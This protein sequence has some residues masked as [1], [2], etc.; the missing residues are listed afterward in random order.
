MEY[1]QKCSIPLLLAVLSFIII[2]SACSPEPKP[3]IFHVG[4]SQCCDDA[5]RD[6]MNRE[7]LRELAFHPEL[8]F[9]IR[10]AGNNSQ[11]QIEQI[12]ELIDSGID[13]LIV[14]PNESEPLTQLVTKV[15]KSGIPVILI[16][17]KIDSEQYSAY[18]GA[19]N[20]EIGETAAKYIANQF[21]GK[22]NIIE[23]Q[24]G[25]TM[26]PA[27][28]RNQGFRDALTKFPQLQIVVPLEMSK[29]MEALKVD[30][31]TTIGQHPEI[32]IVFAHN[33][34]LAENAYTWAKEIGRADDLF[35]IGIDGIPG[36]SKGI[37]AVEDG[38]LNATL[39]YPTGGS[40]AIR[41]ALSMLNNLPFDKQNTLQT[42]VINEDNARI[43]HLQM[44]KVENLQHSIDEQTKG[45]ADLKTV[46]QNQQV[47]IAVLI[48]SLLLAI[49]LGAVLYQSLRSKE[50]INK[51][52]EAK[53]QEALEHEQ[54]IMQMSDQLRLASQAKVEFFT[55][56]S[57]EFRTPLTLI[58]G[59][60]EGLLTT[61][62]I[63][64]KEAKQDLGMVRKN[65]LRLLRLVNQLM[66]F[67]KIES[68]KMAVRAS[69]N[70]LIIFAKDIV[71]AYQKMADKRNIDL[72]FLAH[73]KSILVWFDVNM[74]DKV[75]FNLLSNAFKFTSNGGKIIVSVVKD[76]INNKAIL[77]V[78]DTGRGMT[79]EHTDRAFEQFYQGQN[80]K[81]IGTGLGLSLS[82]ELANLHNGDIKLW[83]ELGKGTRFEVSL[84]LGSLHF[85]EEQLITSKTESIS[86]TE[87][88]LIF[89]EDNQPLASQ[90][91]SEKTTKQSLLLI[92]DNAEM[93]V[94]FKNHFGKIYDIREAADGNT[95]LDLAFEEVPD[96]VVA[97]ITMPGKDGLELAKNLKSDLRTSHI[98]IVLLTARNSMEQKIEGIQTGADAYVT[99][100]FNLVFL[101]EIIKNLLQ[102]RE[103]LR[104]R[105]GGA[106]QLG[107]LPSDLGDLDQQFL[108][109][110][111]TF[112]E[113]NYADLNLTVENLSIEFGL[114]RVQLFRKT[115][116]LLGDSPNNFIQHVR[117]KKASQFLLDS[118]WTVAEIAYKTGYSTPGYFSTAFKGKYGLTPTEWREGKGER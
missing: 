93:R 76:A 87:E 57:H 11:S 117:L 94:F 78:E 109:K 72:V 54:Q 61:G 96:L 44:K 53:T 115:K 68:G 8:D 102:G 12:Q 18:I 6:V 22:G 95:G 116:A 84:P 65:A 73:E 10:T 14:S 75:L 97:D 29:G 79:K 108:R 27:R 38:T 67:R 4:F 91:P 112:V 13:L 66:D 105:F 1:K 64:T 98:P 47:Y 62:N 55:N 56:V 50:E 51:S 63:G 36:I 32:N 24:L 41:L 40:E 17:R 43:L 92:E 69:E 45:L 106:L 74:L 80:N 52:L 3:K 7:M 15:F 25:M 85:R 83:S 33:D 88:M 2:F 31:M 19:N 71:Q 16:D 118:Q 82:K 99:K 30:F 89:E 34:F 48:F 42:I 23:L 103:N 90:Q 86:Y 46:F 111:T 49:I 20:Y 9:K 104:E 39:L 35:F 5:W 28:D 113:A 77:K 26:T 58:L 107:K 81:T 101:S 70:D 60:L 37:Q 114:S 100:P 110:F 59:Y 21:G